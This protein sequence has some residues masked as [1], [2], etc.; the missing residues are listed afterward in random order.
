MIFTHVVHSGA[1]MGHPGRMI[2]PKFSLSSH[3]GK[4]THSQFSL[5]ATGPSDSHS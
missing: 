1:V 2:L 4:I 5:E 3:G